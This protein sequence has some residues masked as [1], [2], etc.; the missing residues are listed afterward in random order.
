MLPRII[1]PGVLLSLDILVHPITLT[2]HKIFPYLA[3]LS[4]AVALF[5]LYRIKQ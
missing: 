5:L 1:I 4:I 2:I 3:I